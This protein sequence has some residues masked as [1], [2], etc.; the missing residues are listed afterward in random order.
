MAGADIELCEY[1]EDEG[2]FTVGATDG[3]GIFAGELPA[4]VINGAALTLYPGSPPEHN[5]KKTGMT[6]E[7]P[8]L[9]L[10]VRNTVEATA[11]T[12]AQDAAKALSKIANQTIEG[13]RFRSVTVLQTPGL[14]YRDAS[15]RPVYGCNIACEREI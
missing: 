14:L 3:T 1:L 8:R 13:T 7:M 5:L 9:Q 4:G 15:N 11:I 12:K 6:L 10:T 2:T